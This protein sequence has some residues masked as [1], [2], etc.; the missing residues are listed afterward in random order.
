M[1]QTF[2][3]IQLDAEYVKGYDNA[4]KQLRKKML[5]AREKIGHTIQELLSIGT[6][7]DDEIIKELNQAFKELS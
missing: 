1:N 7:E 3:E 6:N 5:S 4:T 2:Y